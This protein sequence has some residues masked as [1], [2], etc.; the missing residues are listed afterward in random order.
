MGTCGMLKFS[1]FECFDGHKSE[2]KSLFLCGSKTRVQWLKR[3]FSDIV[4]GFRLYCMPS[5]S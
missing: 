4:I 1:L 5:V 3:T 2:S